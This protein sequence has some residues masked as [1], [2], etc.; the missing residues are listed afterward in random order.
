[1]SIGAA[2]AVGAVIGLA[3]GALGG[4]AGRVSRRERA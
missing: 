3:F 4:L 1:M 2:I